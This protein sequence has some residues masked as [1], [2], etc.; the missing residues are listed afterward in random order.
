VQ[1]VASSN[2]AGPTNSKLPSSLEVANPSGERSQIPLA[3]EISNLQDLF[4]RERHYLK[5][6]SPNTLEW[7]KY[8]FKAF[9]PYIPTSA[10]PKELRAA[11]KAAVMVLAQSKR[12]PITVNDY[13]RAFNAFLRWAF[14]EGHVSELIRLDFLKEEQRLIETLSEEHVR[15]LLSWKPRTFAE[16]RLQALAYLLLDTGLRI[17]EALSIRREDLDLDNMLVT[18]RGKG[19]KFRT[20]PFS[21]EMRKVLFRW[22]QGHSF[23]LVF[24]TIQGCSVNLRNL[25]RDF[26]TL[27]QHVCII[28][29]RFSPHTLR[30]TF[31]VTY[32][33]RGGN[34]FYL[35]KML[36][37]STLEMTNR[38]VRSLGIAD[39]QAVHNGLSVLTN[40]R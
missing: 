16:R 39:L 37:H 33:R 22:N 26:K 24:P 9:A 25:L 2:L 18:V 40:R 35:Q 21:F 8:S 34:V 23:P 19:G 10:E 36:G 38:Y 3:M 17:S 11:L 13:I 28:G 31:A 12:K 6:V 7:Y 14:Q 29:V 27:Q 32:L 30:H 15:R 20:V 5:N 4:T 1:E